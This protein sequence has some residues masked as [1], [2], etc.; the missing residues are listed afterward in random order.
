[1]LGSIAYTGCR[2]DR[3]AHRRT[4]AV[5]L[6][7]QLRHGESRVM[8]VW[9]DRSLIGSGEPPKGVTVTGD[10][11]ARVVAQASSVVFLGCG[12]EA[13]AWFAADLS[14]LAPEQLP[15]FGGG[16]R[17]LDLWRMAPRLDAA[18]G[19]ALAYARAILRW[20]R[21]NGYCG[22][23]GS[24]TVMCEGGH[25]RACTAEVCGEKLF[26]RT[27][28]CVIML[29]TSRRAV[30]GGELPR[31]L[32]G[33]QPAWPEGLMSTLAG[34]VEPGE[35]LEEAVAREVREEVGLDA[36]AIRY[37]GAQ[38]WPFPGS[39]MLGFRAEADAT[40]EL[41][42]DRDELEDARWFT[43]EE[44]LNIEARGMRLPFRGTIA[45]AL[46]DGWL[47]ERAPQAMAEPEPC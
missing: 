9:R 45:R 6:A 44:V 1:M 35:T 37:Q 42:F 26:P 27:D 18:E 13:L 3:A 36:T 10:L 40:A 20:H 16:V 17:F 5:W 46:I 30:R 11:A 21:V 14:S 34:F 15:D 8:P 39:V 29:V 24:P 47:N 43:R 31:C 12:E 4:D 28:P 41:R 2:L 23:C 33:R 7:E 38:P 19:A 25:M 32:L 22:R